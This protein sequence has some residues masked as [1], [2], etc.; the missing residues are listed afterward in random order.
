MRQYSTSK[1]ELIYVKIHTNSTTNI[2]RYTL[3]YIYTYI[4][5]RLVDSFAMI[6]IQ[7]QHGLQF[8]AEG[9]FGICQKQTV[10]KHAR[11]SFIVSKV[12]STHVRANT[13]TY[14][15]AC[16]RCTIYVCLLDMRYKQSS[17]V[18]AKSCALAMYGWRTV[19]STD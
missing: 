17:T 13:H 19:S 11:Q 8:R 2:S 4:S 10:S 6:N 18:L 3:I 12:S 15:L 9:V 5:S 1:N 14:W 16:V 7:P